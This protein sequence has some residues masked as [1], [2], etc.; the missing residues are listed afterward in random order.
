MYLPPVRVV[1][2]Y[3]PQEKHDYTVFGKDDVGKFNFIL[4][5]RYAILLKGYI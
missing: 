1:F 3:Y 4:H 2:A 5:H